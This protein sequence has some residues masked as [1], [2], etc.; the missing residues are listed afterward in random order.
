MLEDDYSSLFLSRR[1]LFF[2]YAPDVT[3][4]NQ[5]NSLS[6]QVFS[7]VHGRPSLL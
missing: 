1:Q 4:F 6:R 5:L 3:H 7:L 2:W